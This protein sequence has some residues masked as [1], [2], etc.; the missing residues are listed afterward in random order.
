MEVAA[1]GDTAGSGG[2]GPIPGSGGGGGVGRAGS[3][4]AGVIAPIAVQADE[5]AHTKKKV[6][7][8]LNHHT[9]AELVGCQGC[10]RSVVGARA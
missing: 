5:P 9:G 1:G 2:G 4:G 3:A 7:D 10:G 6:A 8:F